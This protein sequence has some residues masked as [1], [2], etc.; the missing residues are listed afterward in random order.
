M[1]VRVAWGLHAGGCTLCKH[2]HTAGVAAGAGWRHGPGATG[3]QSPTICPVLSTLALHLHSG[4]QPLPSPALPTLSLSN[5][6]APRNP[7][8][9]PHPSHLMTSPKPEGGCARAGRIEYFSVLYRCS[10]LY[11]AL[12][13]S[14]LRGTAQHSRDSF[15]ALY[16]CAWF[17]VRSLHPPCTAQQSTAWIITA[18]YTAVPG[19]KL[20][21]LPPLAP[22]MGHYVS[23]TG[24]A[25]ALLIIYLLGIMY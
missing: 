3:V 7:P 19:Y 21:S 6:S 4:L 20:R 5:P 13:A 11:R 9:N 8:P 12:S 14:P 24:G 17:T 2:P 23:C 18:C 1:P 10:W 22:N 25:R 16:R 15:S